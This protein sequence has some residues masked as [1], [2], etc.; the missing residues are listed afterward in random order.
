MLEQLQIEGLGH[1]LLAPND[2]RSGYLVVEAAKLIHKVVAIRLA[3]EQVNARIATRVDQDSYFWRQVGIELDSY[4][5]K[6]SMELQQVLK[7][8]RRYDWSLLV[9]T[10]SQEGSDGE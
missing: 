10:G 9:D 4:F 3:R 1:E 2:L 5:A 6:R 7:E 8:A